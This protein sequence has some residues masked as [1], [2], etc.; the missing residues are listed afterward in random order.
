MCQRAFD[1]SQSFKSDDLVVSVVLICGLVGGGA[2]CLAFFV[3]AF[4][5][6]ILSTLQFAVYVDIKQKL[7]IGVILNQICNKN[8]FSSTVFIP[9]KC[10]SV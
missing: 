4:I 2:L 3:L 8:L 5:W 9:F 7:I 1:S 10:F 6:L